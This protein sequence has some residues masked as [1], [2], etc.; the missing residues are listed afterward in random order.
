MNNNI[1]SGGG[2]TGS[3][4]NSN[5]SVVTNYSLSKESFICNECGTDFLNRDTL[6]MHVMENVRDGTCQKAVGE[7]INVSSGTNNFPNGNGS[8]SAVATVGR[9]TCNQNACAAPDHA[10]SPI[11]IDRLSKKS[12]D[13]IRSSKSTLPTPLPGCAQNL[14]KTLINPLTLPGWFRIHQE[15]S[16]TEPTTARSGKDPPWC[17]NMCPYNGDMLLPL[18]H[19]NRIRSDGL[20]GTEAIRR[21]LCDRR[22]LHTDASELRKRRVEKWKESV[23]REKPMVNWLTYKTLAMLNGQPHFK[24]QGALGHMLNVMDY[25]KF[26]VDPLRLPVHPGES[27]SVTSSDNRPEVANSDC[28]QVNSSRQPTP[29][30]ASKSDA[31]SS[32][33]TGDSVLEF[34]V[35]R[36]TEHTKLGGTNPCDSTDTASAIRTHRQSRSKSTPPRLDNQT[37]ITHRSL[38]LQKLDMIKTRGSNSHSEM[39][40][41]S[42]LGSEPGTKVDTMSSNKIWSTVPSILSN[43]PVLRKPGLGRSILGKR[44]NHKSKR[45]RRNT[46]V[47]NRLARR[48]VSPVSGA[49]STSYRTSAS[50]ANSPVRTPVSTVVQ[51][52]RVQLHQTQTTR[53]PIHNS[54][55]TSSMSESG[56]TLKSE[57][58]LPFYCP[59]CQIGFGQK[60]LFSLHMGLHCVDEP[61]KCNM[62]GQ[63]CSGVY[64]FTAHTLHF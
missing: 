1:S 55:F 11:F 12:R 56:A 14:F 49:D 60:T 62:C 5:S 52:A 26:G 19:P 3:I 31:M 25:A 17:A 50:S 37:R 6:A 41:D 57:V 54:E 10:T 16:S 35:S 36:G 2:N 27:C 46:Y 40:H 30:L 59:H 39:M 23:G 64:E 4:T 34:K 53:N 43:R 18:H 28:L 29:T 21:R 47:T 22:D 38:H 45:L 61:W 15:N 51:P 58:R 44:A 7:F 24:M 13:S 48:P 8:N 33:W 63:F 9:H 32:S 42:G 20:T